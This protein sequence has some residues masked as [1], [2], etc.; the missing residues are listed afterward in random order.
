MNKN[1]WDYY[2]K[3]ENNNEHNN[4]INVL[5]I[6]PKNK[7]NKLKVGVSLIS[8]L[9]IF[10]L[11]I[12]KNL[13]LNKESP[14]EKDIYKVR[15]SD[16]TDL[17]DA[18]N[19]NDNLDEKEKRLIDNSWIFINDYYQYIDFTNVENVLEDF[20]VKKLERKLKSIVKD[21]ETVEDLLENN[22]DKVINDLD[23]GIRR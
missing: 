10:Y 9:L 23:I 12:G 7:I 21:Q 22:F 1:Y 6:K 20:D 11:M 13:S 15:D 19:K 4:K 16:P 3:K 5:V 18:I 8:S 17:Y 14:I 2:F